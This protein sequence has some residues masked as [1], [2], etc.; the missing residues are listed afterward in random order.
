MYLMVKSCVHTVRPPEPNQNMLYLSPYSAI[1]EFRKILQK[2]RDS[3]ETD[4]FR[5]SAQNSVFSGKLWSLV[6][7]ACMTDHKSC[8]K[9]RKNLNFHYHGNML[10]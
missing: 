9:T 1:T 5:G 3:A 10:K 2:H 4:K 7:R 8:N 6:I